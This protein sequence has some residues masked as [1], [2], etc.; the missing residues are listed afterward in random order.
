MSL[1][2]NTSYSTPSASSVSLIAPSLHP[3]VTTSPTSIKLVDASLQD[4]LL[5]EAIHTLRASSAVARERIKKREDEMIRNG[6]LPANYA[7]TNGRGGGVEGAKK[8]TTNLA[9]GAGAGKSAPLSEEEEALKMRL[10]ALG[11]H[12]G[13]NIIER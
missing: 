2:P 6:L 8:S 4:Y 12:A 3:L 5:I 9:A 11:A 13:A 7:S 1:L 10:E